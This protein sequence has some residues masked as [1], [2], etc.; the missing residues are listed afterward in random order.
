[1]D[2]GAYRSAIYISNIAA[3]L[4]SL[5]PAGNKLGPMISL[6]M[7]GFLYSVPH[8]LI[9]VNVVSVAVGMMLLAAWAFV[10]PFVTLYLFYGNDLVRAISFY[11]DKMRETVS[12][13]PVSFVQ[14]F[15]FAVVA[16]LILAAGAGVYAYQ[17]NDVAFAKVSEYWRRKLSLNGSIGAATGGATGVIHFDG[18]EPSL[19]KRLLLCLKD[20]S[21]PFFLLSM[22]LMGLFFYFV[23]N[24]WSRTVWLMLRP[25]AIAFLFFYIS[26]SP[27]GSKLSAWMRKSP[28]FSRF[29]EAFDLTV[30][31]LRK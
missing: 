28:R 23:E 30:S 25:L 12:W 27:I 4:K 1:R 26:R 2:R 3:V 29:M 19:R 24:S 7:Q 10:Q 31:K 14:A 15:L 17:A 22:I 5:A 6:S 13:L 18:P 8:A 9:G 11:L 20:L 21:R 16:K